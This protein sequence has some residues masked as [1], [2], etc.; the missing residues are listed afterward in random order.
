[1]NRA[2]SIIPVVK[3]RDLH[4][5]LCILEPDEIDIERI[6]VYKDA[7]VRYEPLHG[8]DG[9]IVRDGNAAIITVKSLSGLKVEKI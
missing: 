2:R 7:Q 8:M 5:E 4:K 3:A 9:R 1:M 6:A